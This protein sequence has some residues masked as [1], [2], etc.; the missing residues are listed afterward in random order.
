LTWSK[1]QGSKYFVFGDFPATRLGA[2]SPP[3][4]NTSNR[5]DGKTLPDVV[6]ETGFNLAGENGRRPR[7]FEF[8]FKLETSNL[9]L[10]RQEVI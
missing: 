9:E 6:P 5:L 4:I 2:A 3:T 1:D 10:R 8:N 7:C